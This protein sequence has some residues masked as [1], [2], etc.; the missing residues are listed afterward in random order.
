MPAWSLLTPSNTGY[1]LITV[2]F[3]AH[4]STTLG[5]IAVITI[6]PLIEYLYRGL[7]T[8]CHKSFLDLV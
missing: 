5:G 7:H 8:R 3:T 6:L 4:T 1:A 2:R